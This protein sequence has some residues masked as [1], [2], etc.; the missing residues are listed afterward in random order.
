MWTTT[1]ELCDEW[2]FN[3]LQSTISAST[4]V[5]PIRLTTEDAAKPNIIS[6]TIKKE[7]DRLKQEKEPL[8]IK[9]ILPKGTFTEALH[10]TQL[11][12]LE[13]E[14]QEDTILTTAIMPTIMIECST[15]VRIKNLKI[16][17]KNMTDSIKVLKGNVVFEKCS[18]INNAYGNGI[19][20]SGD[21]ACYLSETSIEGNPRG[22]VLV[23][24]NGLC[25]LKRS[26]VQA[27]V[28]LKKQEN[29][30]Y[31]LYNTTIAQL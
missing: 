12:T 16:H 4:A 8:I 19:R 28:P 27:E 31:R 21:S 26:K 24:E 25:I 23:E 29:A 2:V 6:E 18:I 30:L 5:K 3:I 11:H 17:N 7:V 10:I 15:N 9:I 13:I 22:G 14:G 20:I 1:I